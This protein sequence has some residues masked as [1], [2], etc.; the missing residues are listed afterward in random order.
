LRSFVPISFAP[1]RADDVRWPAA[2][3]FP[4]FLFGPTALILQILVPYSFFSTGAAFSAAP[5]FALKKDYLHLTSHVSRPTASHATTYDFSFAPLLMYFDLPPDVLF[6]SS[7]IRAVGGARNTSPVPFFCTRIQASPAT[8]S[9]T[10]SSSAR[11]D[12]KLFLNLGHPLSIPCI[13]RRP[14]IPDGPYFTSSAVQGVA[15]PSPL[16]HGCASSCTVWQ[17]HFTRRSSWSLL[18]FFLPFGLRDLLSFP[19]V[20]LSLYTL[21]AFAGRSGLPA[22]VL[23]SARVLRLRHCA[24]I[25]EVRSQQEIL[26][27]HADFL[28]GFRSSGPPMV[29]SDEAC[30]ISVDKLEHGPVHRRLFF[31]PRLGPLFSFS[32]CNFAS[33][34]PVF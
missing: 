11:V 22:P 24:E 31:L 8:P 6:F 14:L 9:G 16:P 32:Q 4:V 30:P 26:L 1:I 5:P 21:V 13:R 2:S 27:C 25:F 19:L 33:S 17:V 20:F 34:S 18:V 12:A 7:T 15:T 10:C 29:L 28:H 3:A 23:S